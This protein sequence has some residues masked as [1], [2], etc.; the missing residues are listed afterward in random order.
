MKKKTLIILITVVI[1][2]V[3]AITAAIILLRIDGIGQ[4]GTESESFIKTTLYG[5]YTPW[6]TGKI[7]T[8]VYT[9]DN[10][11]KNRKLSRDEKKEINECLEQA[12]KELT[13]DILV[14]GWCR[15]S[16]NNR[17]MFNAYQY[18]DG[19]VVPDVT[20]RLTQDG[21]PCIKHTGDIP[22]IC[23]LDTAGMID[24]E[25]LFSTVDELALQHESE[26]NMDRD[27]K[28]YVIYHPEYDTFRDELY[29][30]F[31]I[32]EYSRIRIDAKTGDILEEHYF[33][34]EFID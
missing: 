33:N 7:G 16:E 5:S 34:G 1:A 22:A 28:I 18:F 4:T 9:T 8:H 2:V 21:S 19:V 6:V 3:L 29:Y 24:P 14:V 10:V 25:E 15:L 27:K 32:N 30:Y 23:S 13:E 26:L 12:D 17:L 11:I 31:S 20:Y